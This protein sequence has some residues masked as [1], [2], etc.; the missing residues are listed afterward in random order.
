MAPPKKEKMP[1]MKEL[2][3]LLAALDAEGGLSIGGGEEDSTNLDDLYEDSYFH[4]ILHNTVT[5]DTLTL[6]PTTTAP[7][8]TTSPSDHDQGQERS[9]QTSAPSFQVLTLPPERSWGDDH[10]SLGPRLLIRPGYAVVLSALEQQPCQSQSIF[11]ATASPGMG[12]SCLAYYLV[13][14][15]FQTGH[16]VVIS[17]PM[18]TNAFINREYYS[19]Y[20]PHLEKHSIISKAISTPSSSE[21]TTK[22][23][24]WVCDDGFLPIKGTRCNVLITSAT[25]QSAKDSETVTKKNKLVTPI[26]FQIPKWSLDEIKAGMIVSLSTLDAGMGLTDFKITKEQEPVLEGL[27][28]KFKGNPRKIFSWVKS[29]WVVAEET[30]AASGP[31]SGKRK[32]KSSKAKKM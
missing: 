1:S 11:M 16:D 21:G 7:P 2:Q 31:N 32:A 14:K 30:S 27:F 26:Q 6:E 3:D 25:T 20:S 4:A 23:L 8:T 17:D 5:Q 15:L 22:P 18:F 13:H 24:W 10:E 29:N 19:S 12:K 9:Q 28:Q